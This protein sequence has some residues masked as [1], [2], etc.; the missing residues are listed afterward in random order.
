MTE[1]VNKSATEGSEDRIILDWHRN[2]PEQRL[3]FNGGRYTN[4]HK[5]LCFGIALLLTLLF[6]AVLIFTAPRL[7]WLEGFADIFVNR[8][9]TQYF[10]VLFFFWVLAM[11]AMKKRKL[12]FQM[13]AFEL[14][15]FPADAHFVLTPDTAQDVTRRMHDMVDSP[16]H[17]AVLSRVE[18]ALS[19]L[20]NIGHT[21]DVT[22]ILKDQSENDESQVAASYVLVNGLMWAVPVLGFIGTVLGL[23][24]AIGEFGN[25]L[26]QEGDFSGIKESLTGVTGG[27]ATAFDTTLVA[28]VLALVLQLVISF[29]QSRESAWLDACNEYCSRQ[30]ASRLRLRQID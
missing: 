13:K 25:T 10:A 28:L 2:D 7:S 15:V 9:P 12:G 26:K 27:L 23:S 8:G 14:P 29:V 21:A 18:R 17:F 20:E 24:T 16:A 5:G 30:L 4:P 11:L 1:E 3:G 19:N 22:A 6:F